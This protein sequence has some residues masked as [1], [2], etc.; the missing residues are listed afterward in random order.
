ME[1]N[2]AGADDALMLDGRG[3]VAE[4]NATHLFAVDRRERCVTPHTVACPEGITRQTVLDLAPRRG[5]RGARC[6]TSRWPRCTPP[7]RCSAPGRWARSPASPT[8]DGRPIGDGMVGPVTAERGRDLPGARAGQRRARAHVSLGGGELVVVRLRRLD[9][10]GRR[11]AGHLRRLSGRRARSRSTRSTAAYQCGAHTPSVSRRPGGQR[12]IAGSKAM[13]SAAQSAGSDLRPGR[14]AGRPRRRPAR[15]GR[16]RS[17]PA[18]GSRGRR[19]SA[20]RA[21][22]RSWPRRAPGRGSGRR[23]SA[24]PATRGR[25]REAGGGPC[26]SGS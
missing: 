3:F 12:S 21:P 14:G 13:P 7:T 25:P 23:W 18:A 6:A 4:T 24:G 26:A 17:P 20:R 10:D 9:A 1:A 22:W 11:C 8:I 19:A 2:V 16:G 5:H 15:R